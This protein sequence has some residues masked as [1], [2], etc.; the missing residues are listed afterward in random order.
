MFPPTDTYNLH[1]SRIPYEESSVYSLINFCSPS[2]SHY[3][4]KTGYIIKHVPPKFIAMLTI[5]FIS[6]FLKIWPNVTE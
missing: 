4:G 2:P 3:K 1:P 6:H 5:S